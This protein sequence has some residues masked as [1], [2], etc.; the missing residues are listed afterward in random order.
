MRIEVRD[1]ERPDRGVE[2]LLGDLDGLREDL[3]QLDV[4]DVGRP[5]AG[6]APPGARSSTLEDVNALLVTL[7]AAPALL[8][9]VVG[10]VARW[11]GRTSGPAPDVSLRMGDRH[12][13]LTG[14]DPEQ[15]RVLTAMWLEACAA[16]EERES[17]R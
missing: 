9:Q 6:P 15:Q 1:A 2:S 4:D 11:R 13:E 14:G 10:V 3:L 5:D 12:L 8:H 7:T 16:S 17:S